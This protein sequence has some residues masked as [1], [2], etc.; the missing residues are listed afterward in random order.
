MELNWE[1]I[2]AIGEIGGAI[3][4]VVTLAYLALQ[5]RESRK[6]TLADV[7]QTRAHSRGAPLLQVALNS[8]TFH[9]TLF[10]FE[11]NLENEGLDAAIADLSDEERYLV[12]LYHHDLM[13]R[14]DNIHFQYLQGFLPEA[15][16][17]STKLGM[18]RF[19]PIWEALELESQYPSI[20]KELFETFGSKGNVSD[21]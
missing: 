20:S 11:T 14:T 18:Q 19:V 2:G 16:F 15:Y 4:V 13:V 6:A 8:P 3:A 5:V 1:A 17:E 9:K 10:R 12:R 21:A 7:Y